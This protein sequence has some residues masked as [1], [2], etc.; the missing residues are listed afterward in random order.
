[1]AV[2]M[3]PLTFRLQDLCAAKAPLPRPLQRLVSACIMDAH[4]VAT[5]AR[6]LRRFSISSTRWPGSD[7]LNRARAGAQELL[8]TVTTELELERT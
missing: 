1:M 7:A 4:C 2:C 5:L 8:S 6:A 3:L